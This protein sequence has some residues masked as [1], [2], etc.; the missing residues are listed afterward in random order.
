[1]RKKLKSVLQS[2]GLWSAFERLRFLHRFGW[3]YRRIAGFLD[4]PGWLSP[5]DAT[6]LYDAVLSL[7]S[8]KPVIVEI[9]S[10]LGKSSMVLAQA[11]R[12]KGGGILHCIDPFDA[13]GD[14][15][16]QHLYEKRKAELG[17]NLLEAFERNMKRYGVLSFVRPVN[18]FSHEVAKEFS[19][20][21]DMLFI[22]GNHDYEAVKRDFVD[23]VPRLRVGGVIA[24]HDV[25]ATPFGG[26][27]TGP[28][29]VADELIVGSKDWR[30]FRIRDITSF[31]V[32][33]APAS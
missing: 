13:S 23:W 28:W 24:M 26:D 22:D 21:I 9:G 19:G 32:K 8:E 4:I 7:K 6:E 20:E 25:F 31:A 12:K 15:G 2:L 29:R 18:G 30:W 14:L 17:M 33:V 27:Y 3:R 5:Q 10:H 16:A 11:L 1:M